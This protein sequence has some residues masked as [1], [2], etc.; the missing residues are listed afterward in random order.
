MEPLA[1]FTVHYPQIFVTCS[2]KLIDCLTLL[3]MLLQFQ[4]AKDVSQPHI[5]PD[6]ARMVKTSLLF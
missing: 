1:L 2:T 4:I 6:V 3:A 5:E